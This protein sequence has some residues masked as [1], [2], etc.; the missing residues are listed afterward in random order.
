MVIYRFVN[1]RMQFFTFEI[2]QVSSFAVCE[3]LFTVN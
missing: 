3:V 1:A 2:L